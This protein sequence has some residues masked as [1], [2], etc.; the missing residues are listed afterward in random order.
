MRRAG[1]RWV[2]AVTR[3]EPICPLFRRWRHWS[4]ASPSRG[5]LEGDASAVSSAATKVATCREPFRCIRC[6]HPGHRE[7]NYHRRHR[8]PVG[9]SPKSRS[10]SPAIGSP[11]PT[12][13][14]TWAEV[15]RPSPPP[16]SPSCPPGVGRNAT[17]SVGPDFDLQA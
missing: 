16:A 13:S 8:S 6:C 14:R 15:V 11:R 1:S 9:R 12:H 3:P 17:V 5:G 4:G 10:H 2:L 7:R